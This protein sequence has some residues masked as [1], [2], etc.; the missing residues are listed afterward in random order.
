MRIQDII[1]F[2]A[3]DNRIL[4]TVEATQNYAKNSNYE[5]VDIWS[6]RDPK[7]QSIQLNE[8]SSGVIV[9]V[10]VVFKDNDNC[11]LRYHCCVY[12]IGKGSSGIF[13]GGQDEHR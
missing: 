9:F 11:F 13:G 6:Y 8:T 4:F 3:T 12:G 5:P 2:K 7:L 10:E 1:L